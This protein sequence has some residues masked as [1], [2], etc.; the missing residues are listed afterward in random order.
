MIFAYI[1]VG[2][3]RLMVNTVIMGVVLLG[4]LVFLTCYITV[5]VPMSLHYQWRIR[6]GYRHR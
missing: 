1:I 4:A 5:R 6:N 2:L 3:V